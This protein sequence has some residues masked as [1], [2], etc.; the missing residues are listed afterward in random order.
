M[1]PNG[2]SS[3]SSVKSHYELSPALAMETFCSLVTYIQKCKIGEA[4]KAFVCIINNSHLN[5]CISLEVVVSPLTR[6][7][8]LYF[9]SALPYYVQG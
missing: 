9:C 8:R 1:W 5:L 6:E 7:D 3:P 4:D 2:M